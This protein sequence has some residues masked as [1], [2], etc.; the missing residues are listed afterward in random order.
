MHD[1]SIRVTALLETSV[2][3]DCQYPLTLIEHS[4][5][6]DLLLVLLQTVCSED[7][8]LFHWI[9]DSLFK[10]PNLHYLSNS[11]EILN[12]AR[13]LSIQA[14][15]SIFIFY[16]ISVNEVNAFISSP[17]NDSPSSAYS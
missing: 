17:L 8:I 7:T 11:S 16:P 6:T 2:D 15:E 1:C 3:T 10:A 12:Q 4:V 13:K 9:T 14:A 5:D